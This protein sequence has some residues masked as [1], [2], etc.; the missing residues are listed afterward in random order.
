MHSLTHADFFYFYFQLMPHWC[1][2]TVQLYFKLQEKFSNY[3]S[4]NCLPS[5][6]KLEVTELN[7]LRFLLGVNK[8]DSEMCIRGTAKFKYF[9]HSEKERLTSTLDENHVYNLYTDM[10]F[11]IIVFLY[12]NTLVL[13]YI[14]GNIKK[15]FLKH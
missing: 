6:Q 12:R 3:S 15:R 5:N 9:G 1:F 11:H 4:P 2:L 10:I 7:M 8:R 14:N 13:F